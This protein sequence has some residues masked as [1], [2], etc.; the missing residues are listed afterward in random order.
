MLTQA[1]QPPKARAQ[2]SV[3]SMAR[4][5]GLS[6]TRVQQI[7]SRNDLKPHLSQTFKLSN[8]P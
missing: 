1:T 5:A 2:W 7:W 8:D 6:K 3:R 4:H